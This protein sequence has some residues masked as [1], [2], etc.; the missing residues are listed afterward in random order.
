[1]LIRC[2]HE[3]LVEQFPPT[4]TLYCS[5]LW[6]RNFATTEHYISEYY[7]TQLFSKKC[8][9]LENKH[10][11]WNHS[12]SKDSTR[13]SYLMNCK[14]KLLWAEYTAWAYLAVVK[15]KAVR[16]VFWSLPGRLTSRTL[17][18]TTLAEW[19]FIVIYFKQRL[20]YG[21]NFSVSSGSYSYVCTTVH[22]DQNCAD[23]EEKSM[24][25]KSGAAQY[26]V[27]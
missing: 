14:T 20:F 24:T 1:M 6:F 18:W 4:W 8:Y 12:I 13:K 16:Q 27:I 11:R 25:S 15:I 5:T 21:D 22:K 23:S 19:N 17:H 3:T 10:R 9:K 7:Y 26:R 2:L